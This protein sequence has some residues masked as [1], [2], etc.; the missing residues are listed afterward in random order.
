MSHSDDVTDNLAPPSHLMPPQ[1]PINIQHEQHNVNHAHDTQ[2]I[3]ATINPGNFGMGMDQPSIVYSDNSHVN[4]GDNITGKKDD[5]MSGNSVNGCGDVGGSG[6]PGNVNGG[7]MG[8]SSSN[9]GNGGEFSHNQM[10]SL[11]DQVSELQARLVMME[12]GAM[13]VSVL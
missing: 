9:N 13:T 12:A 8:G 4:G 1:T 11:Q 5:S 2:N 10:A 3:N 6:M 7:A